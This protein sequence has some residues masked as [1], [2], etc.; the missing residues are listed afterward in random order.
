MNAPLLL[1]DLQNDYLNSPAL[2]P[3]REILVAK[4]AKLLEECRTRNAPVIHVWTTIS[5]DRDGRLP[6]WKKLNRWNCVAGTDGHRTPSSL[7]PVNGEAIV[8]KTG[9]NGFAS[10]KLDVA[11]KE[12]NGDA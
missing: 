3:S 7:Q 8:H 6:H 10:G 4:A 12:V 1:V 11:L 2:Q 9:F 5:R